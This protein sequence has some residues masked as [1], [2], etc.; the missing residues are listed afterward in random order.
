MADDT[1][2]GD[3]PDVAFLQLSDVVGVDVDYLLD[4]GFAFAVFE[5]FLAVLY[6]AFVVDVDDF[7]FG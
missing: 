3:V 5:E 6:F 1:F 4:I 7:G 2:Q